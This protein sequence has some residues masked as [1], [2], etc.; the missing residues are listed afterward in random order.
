[1]KRTKVP[2]NI[3]ELRQ[4]RDSRYLW[5]PERQNMIPF[6]VCLKICQTRCRQFKIYTYVEGGFNY[7]E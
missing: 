2:I 1:M 5:C 7:E 6:E 3:E 4:L